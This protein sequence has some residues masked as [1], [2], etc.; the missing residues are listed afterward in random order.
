LA[1]ESSVTTEKQ[2]NTYHEYDYLRIPR[3]FA[4]EETGELTAEPDRQLKFVLTERQDGLDY[5]AKSMWMLKV[6]KSPRHPNNGVLDPEVDEYSRNLV[7]RHRSNHLKWLPPSHSTSPIRLA[8]LPMCLGSGLLVMKREPDNSQNNVSKDQVG[9]SLDLRYR[10]TGQAFRK[11]KLPG[12]VA[13][14]AA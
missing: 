6:R 3:I 2:V 13:R 9:I 12:F 10:P 7:R 8:R 1:K 5:G 11:L 14:N 4:L